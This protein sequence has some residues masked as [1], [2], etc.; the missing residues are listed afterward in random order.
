MTLLG[1]PLARALWLVGGLVA[2]ALGIVG[3]VLPLL[4]TTPFV[5]LAAFCFARSSPRLHRWLAT[6]RLF[7]PMIENWAR[8]G[9]IPRNAKRLALAM[10][11]GA[12]ALSLW[13]GLPWQVLAIQAVTLLGAA[14][15]VWTR[16]DPPA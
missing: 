12:F 5:I 1:A 9:A 6:H 3:A 7:G 4:P 13:M 2:L 11:A 10:M 8:H 15:F 16:P 14:T